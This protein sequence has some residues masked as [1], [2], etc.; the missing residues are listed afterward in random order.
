MPAL[1]ACTHSMLLSPILISTDYFTFPGKRGWLKG[2]VRGWGCQGLAVADFEA[3][4][5]GQR[6]PGCLWF[7]QRQV[8][9]RWRWWPLSCWRSSGYPVPGPA[10]ASA[11]AAAQGRSQPVASLHPSRELHAKNSI[12]AHAS[13]QRP[14]ARHC[15]AWYRHHALRQCRRDSVCADCCADAIAA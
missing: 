9:G 4:S 11:P 12:R 8:T 13:V 10:A 7:G 15:Q 6:R 1:C 14:S 3:R 5:S 2:L